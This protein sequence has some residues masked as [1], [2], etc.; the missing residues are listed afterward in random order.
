[1]KRAG[2]GLALGACAL[3]GALLAVV[4]A[5]PIPASIFQTT[6]TTTGHT[7]TSGTT[8]TAAVTTTPTTITTPI[9]TTAP[10][11]AI[12]SGV[13]IG[14]VKVGGLAPEVATDLI[15]TAFAAPL[16][17]RFGT[18]ALQPTPAGLGATAYVKQAVNKAL[19]AAPGANVPLFVRV[20]GAR[21]RAY[22]AELAKRFDREPVDSKL[23]LRGLNPF[24]T[25]GAPGRALDR[26]GTTKAIVGALAGNRRFPIELAARRVE[27]TVSRNSF[28]PVIVIRRSSKR[29]HLYNG[30]RPWRIFAVAT[31]QDRYPTPLGRF[32]I[33]VKWINPTWYPPDSDWAKGQEP[34]PPG[35]GNPLGTRWMGISS[36]G[37]GIHGTPDAGSIGYSVS[38]GC[39]RMQIPDAEWLFTRVSVGTPVFIVAA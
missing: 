17:L 7:T 13:R 2:L 32:E 20:D 4:L 11:A 15:R 21:V 25:N 16:V 33:V 8:T 5:G 30:M 38:H 22:V 29:L 31:G 3:A 10:K 14:G 28:G 23:F 1:V 26:K 9:T 18:R 37:V 36:P 12:A 39:I 35:P 34:I 6:E 27:Q 24:I 19:R